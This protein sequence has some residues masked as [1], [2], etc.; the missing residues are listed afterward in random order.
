MGLDTTHDCFHGP[1][2][3]FMQWREWLNYF[4]MRERAKNGDVNA[5]EVSH[6]GVTREALMR[7]WNEGL[8]DDQSVPINVLM[9][10]SD[11]DGEITADMCA[12]LADALQALADQYMPPRGT[13]DAM[14]PATD[15]FIKGL[16][17][18]AS[19][20]EPVTFA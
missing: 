10:H 13:Y 4:V 20:N 6:L 3:Q 18:A 1:Y 17:L 8:Y 5:N 7:A 16:R 12:P 14:R 11:C 19:R 9:A 2:S 15:R